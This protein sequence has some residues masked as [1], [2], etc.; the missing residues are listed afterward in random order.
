MDGEIKQQTERAKRYS[1]KGVVFRRDDFVFL[2]DV[3]ITVRRPSRLYLGSF[4][5]PRDDDDDDDTHT[6]RVVVKKIKK[7]KKKLG[8]PRLGRSVSDG[9][10]VRRLSRTRFHV[11]RV[12]GTTRRVI[13]RRPLVGPNDNTASGVN[14]RSSGAQIGF[15]TYSNPVRDENIRAADR[16]LPPFGFAVPPGLF[17]ASF[18]YRTV[19][20]RVR[21]R[22][23]P[24]SHENVVSGKST[25][26][27]AATVLLGRCS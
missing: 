23:R 25:R 4:V 26:R 12:R 5:G 18:S 6:C 24:E 1:R 9:R 22:D 8:N 27:C 21:E 7:K 3:V 2:S 19:R 11:V 15:H 20:R 10:G 17:T 14:G 13:R 16:D